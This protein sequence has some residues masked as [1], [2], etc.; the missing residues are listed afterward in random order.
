MLALDVRVLC[1]LRA[2][3]VF[4]E[5]GASMRVCPW[6]QQ[7]N[8]GVILGFQTGVEWDGVGSRELA[9]SQL[10]LTAAP[11]HMVLPSCALPP[12]A[13]IQNWNSLRDE[14]V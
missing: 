7:E 2:L 9:G 13:T 11:P 8:R 6:L 10:H 3:S 14:L 1:H 4:C 12:S 5:V